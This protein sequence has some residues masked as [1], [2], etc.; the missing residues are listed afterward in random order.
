MRP[1]VCFEAAGRVAPGQRTCGYREPNPGTWGPVRSE[2]A[3]LQGLLGDGGAAPESNYGRQPARP[4]TTTTGTGGPCAVA[5]AETASVHEG[6]GVESCA[7][8]AYPQN[9][10]E[11]QGAASLVAA[12][13]G[14]TDSP[15]QLQCS[16]IALGRTQWNPGGKASEDNRNCLFVASFQLSLRACLGSTRHLG[17]AGFGLTAWLPFRCT[18]FWPRP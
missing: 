10:R 5:D 16:W 2:A 9:G 17:R 3:V 7:G 11:R 6:G 4:A 13:T 12:N 18:R 1:R 15:P 8:L 14:E